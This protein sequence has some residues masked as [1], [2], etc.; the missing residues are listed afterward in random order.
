MGH[1]NNRWRGIRH[2][3]DHSTWILTSSHMTHLTVSEHTPLRRGQLYAKGA[4]V[5]VGVV[6]HSHF[7]FAV[8]E[9]GE[10]IRLDPWILFWQM[11]LDQ[12]ASRT[13]GGDG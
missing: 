3:A 10:I 2:W 1:N 7:A 11:Y 6:E 5:F 9:R 13:A 12:A 8:V 4:G